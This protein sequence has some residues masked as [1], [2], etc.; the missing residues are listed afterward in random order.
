[1]AKLAI[2]QSLRIIFESRDCFP[3]KAEIYLSAVKTYQQMGEMYVEQLEEPMLLTVKEKVTW[4]RPEE[5][6]LVAQIYRTIY[7]TR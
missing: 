1:M 4:N 3:K 2:L 5:M 7:K 6:I